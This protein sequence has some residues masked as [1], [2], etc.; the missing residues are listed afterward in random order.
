MPTTTKAKPRLPRIPRP[1][2]RTLAPAPPAR[3]IAHPFTHAD[4][5]TRCPAC[6]LRE[7]LE[8]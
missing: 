8:A 5:G 4:N 3:P 2:R 7:Y 1:V 6:E